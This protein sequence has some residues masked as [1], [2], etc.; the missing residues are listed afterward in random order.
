MAQDREVAG[1]RCMEVL[2]RL[3]DY[4]DGD[5]SAEERARVDGHLADC[6]WCARFGGR[7]TALLDAVR[8]DLGSTE[9]PSADL[10]DR[11]LERLDTG[12]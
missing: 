5:L 3:S 9:E 4:V 6:N 10:T 2:D 1:I 11:V 12:R 7:F 8:E